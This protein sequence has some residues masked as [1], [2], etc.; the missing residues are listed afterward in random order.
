M[1]AR[2]KISWNIREQVPIPSS[3]S[4]LLTWCERSRSSLVSPF[5]LFVNSVGQWLGEEL[6]LAVV[7]SCTCVWTRKQGRAMEEKQQVERPR[8]L[9]CEGKVHGTVSWTMLTRRRVNAFMKHTS[10]VNV[11]EAAIFGANARSHPLYHE[12]TCDLKRGTT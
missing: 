2:S 12:R 11:I 7:R 5:V 10:Q 1:V 9:S 4:K 8:I 3:L 6:A